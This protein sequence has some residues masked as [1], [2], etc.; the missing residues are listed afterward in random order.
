MQLLGI[1]H[2]VHAYIVHV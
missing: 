2:A 1:E